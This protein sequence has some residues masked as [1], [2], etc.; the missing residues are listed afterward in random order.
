VLKNAEIKLIT[1]PQLEEF[2]LKH[3]YPKLKK[4]NVLK[5]Y[6]PDLKEK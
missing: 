2:S 1:V 3:I 4:H 6:L 5:N